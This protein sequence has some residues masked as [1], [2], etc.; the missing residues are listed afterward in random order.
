MRIAKLFVGVLLG[1]LLSGGLINAQDYPVK[2]VRLVVP[3]PPGGA[4]DLIARGLAKYLA[5]KW[6]KPVIVDNRGGAAGII[7]A[8][9]VSRAAPDGYT[10]M[11]SDSSPFVIAP[12]LQANMPFNPLTAFAPITIVAR[13]SQVLAVG[14]K[15]PVTNVKELVLYLKANPGTTYGSFGEGSTNHVL[16]EE[17]ARLSGTKLVHVPYKGTGA[18][19]PDLLSGRIGI[20]FGS[21]G[22]LEPYEKAGKLKLLAVT[23]E[24]RLPFRPD[25]PTFN[26]SDLPGLVVSLWMGLVA[27]AGTPPEILGKIQRDVSEILL[28]RTFVDQVLS[29]QTLIPGGDSREAFGAQLR[30]DTARWG[31]LVKGIGL[32]P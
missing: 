26:E 20:Y 17:F 31:S 11:L 3:Y 15:I 23:N 7:G 24:K 5:D 29:P 14:E 8:E 4:T 12:H 27:P 28:D 9:A 16:T 19:I 10:L 2:G 32:K 18:V 21:L 30:Q 6:G 25:L 13:Q 22:V 1:C